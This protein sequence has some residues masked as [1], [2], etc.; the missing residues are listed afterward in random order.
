MS[1]I[2][3]LFR[4]TCA[5]FRPP[6]R[7]T[8]SEW[9][10]KNRRLVS[11]GSAESG[12][13]DTDRA[14]YQREIMDAFTQPEVWEIVVMSSSQIGKALAIDTPIATPDGWKTM[15]ELKTGDTIFDE[16]GNPCTVTYVT[17]VMYDRPCFKLTFSDGSEIVAD[18]EHRWAVDEDTGHGLKKELHHVVA[19]ADIADRQSYTDSTGKR[20]NR[21]S[22]PVASALDL[23]EQELPFPPY[24]LGVWL[25]D[26]NSHS[27]ELTTDPKDVEILDYIRTEGIVVESREDKRGLITSILNPKKSIRETDFCIRGHDMRILGRTK[28]G[29]CAECARQYSKHFQYGFVMDPVLNTKPT[30][31]SALK[32]LGVL[33]NKH[34][35]TSYL[36][37]SKQQRLALLQGLMD[38]DGTISKTGVC[39]FTQKSERL[40]MDM[41]ELL[42]SLG[43]KHKLSTKKATC[44]YNGNKYECDVYRI[45]FVCYAETPVF[46]LKRK[47]SRQVSADSLGPAGKPRRTT[48]TLRRRIISA[49]PVSSVPV[50]CIMVDSPNHLYLAGRSMIPTH[51]TELLLNMIGYVIDVDPGPMLFVQPTDKTGEDYSKRR[52]APMI[53]ACPTLRDKVYKAK[54]RDSA[55]TMTMKTFPGGSLAIIGANS[56]ADLASKPIRYVF[57]D[58]TDRFPPSAGT[59]GDPQEL[60]ERRTETFRHNRKVVKTSTPTVKGRSN[61]ES[62]YMKGTQEEWQTECPYCRTYSFIQFPQIKFEKDEETG[63]DGSTTYYVRSVKW[64][65]PVCEHEFDEWETKRFP[66]KWVANNPN[67]ISNG[68]RSFRL[69]AFMSP[70]SD[71]KDIV[72][73]FLEAKSDPQKLQ[74]VCNTMFGESWEVR[75]ENDLPEKLY[76]RREHYDAELPAGV[77]VL[78]MGVDTQDNRLEYEV[79]GWDRDCQSWGISRGVIPGR[80]DAPGVW[81]EIDALLDHEWTFA[82]GR[83][84]RISATFIDS[85]GHF[86]GDVYRETA[87][88]QSKR[89]WAI[90]GESGEGKEYCRIMKNATS[91]VSSVKFMVG[92]DAGKGGIMYEAGI[93]EP[94]P[95][96]MHFPL[97]Y[98]AG[99]DMEF[100][101]GLISER[102]VIH[103]R[104]GKS[105]AAWEKIYKRNEPLDCRNYA[106]AAYRYFNWHFNEI[107]RSIR[108]IEET[109]IITKAEETRRKQRHIVSR[110]IRV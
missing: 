32:E 50:K 8:V 53:A 109:K 42:H 74:V 3:E 27:A 9:A 14:P 87:K 29:L 64:Q 85:G 55:N 56:P 28:K 45:Q 24:A 18:A 48:E 99:Y 94:G 6:A 36:R 1:A 59:E 63:E 19:T 92:V 86:T 58:E 49:K 20:H 97:D 89:V 82:N 105:T 110:G 52:V 44:N 102:L 61:I 11:E 76:N 107:E 96:Y 25:G 69:N 4:F 26:G 2:A 79:V 57:M 98:H 106:R 22:I 70:W 13:W 37:A 84:I 73:K 31:H 7:L 23:P 38:T 78:T 95:N 67:A 104:A 15:G 81:D 43:I 101:K 5:M 54:G 108:G 90:K 41:S 35:P 34:I 46:R 68:I 16:S 51:N 75:L 10:D 39:E 33:K 40:T 88:R 65:C 60:A 100:F 30:G 21:F 103:R 12:A 66:G 83:S 77:L 93:T 80:A 62:D 17:D 91:E 47:L 71:W 72:R